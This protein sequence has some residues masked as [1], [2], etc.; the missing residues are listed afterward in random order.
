MQLLFVLSLVVVVS[1]Y[2]YLEGVVTA[3]RGSGFWRIAFLASLFQ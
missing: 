2:L 3:L 1:D